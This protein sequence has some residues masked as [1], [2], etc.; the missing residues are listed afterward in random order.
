MELGIEVM[1]YLRISLLK[2]F[3]SVLC[4]RSGAFQRQA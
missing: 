4:G 3:N 1:F 2:F